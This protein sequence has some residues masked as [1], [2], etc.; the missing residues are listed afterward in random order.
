MIRF[1]ILHRSGWIGSSD[2][3]PVHMKKE[4]MQPLLP[5]DIDVNRQTITTLDAAWDRAG[6]LMPPDVRQMMR[7]ERE[8]TAGQ[9]LLDRDYAP[10]AAPETYEHL[11]L[12]IGVTG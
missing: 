1:H 10:D 11:L 7:N 3:R 12:P 9:E 4:R 8:K 5:G 2:H 6:L